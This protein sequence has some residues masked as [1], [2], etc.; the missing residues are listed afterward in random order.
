M[1]IY[2][3]VVDKLNTEFNFNDIYSHTFS[4]NPFCYEYGDGED[5][6]SFINMIVFYEEDDKITDLEEVYIICREQAFGY[7]EVMKIMHDNLSK[8]D[9]I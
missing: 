5:I 7:L 1:S 4:G 9:Q 2:Q 8:Y 6:I 3:S